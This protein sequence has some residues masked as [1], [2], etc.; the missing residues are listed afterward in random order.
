[1]YE[2]LVSHMRAA[3][4]D[5]LALLSTITVLI[6]DEEY[7]LWSSSLRSFLQPPVTT[8]LKYCLQGPFLEYALYT[9]VSLR[10]L[11]RDKE[12]AQGRGPEAISWH[13]S[14]LRRR[15]LIS[16]RIVP[17]RPSAKAYWTYLQ[18]SARLRTNKKPN[19]AM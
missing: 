14:F 5:N 13:A 17:C 10:C 7:K 9:L 16:W 8:S 6:F 15:N 19:I 2:F 18:L 3:F 11:S 4:C 1:M 12:S